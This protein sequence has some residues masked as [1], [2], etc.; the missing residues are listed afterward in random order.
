M[1][2]AWGA[3][4]GGRSRARARDG[5]AGA[6]PLAAPMTIK[7]IITIFYS[8]RSVKFIPTPRFVMELLLEG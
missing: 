7:H 8:P 3:A 5:G 2:F 4:R 6:P 1:H